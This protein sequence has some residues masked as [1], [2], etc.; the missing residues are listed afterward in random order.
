MHV[1]SSNKYNFIEF[2]CLLKLMVLINGRY[3]YFSLILIEVL[4]STKMKNA[5][6]ALPQ[7]TVIRQFA[8]YYSYRYNINLMKSLFKFFTPIS[9]S[10]ID[11]HFFMNYLLLYRLKHVLIDTLMLPAL[12]FQRKLKQL[13]LTPFV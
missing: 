11:C 3:I 2:K 7:L 5:I 1:D 9:T 6:V 10:K 8:L 4:F 13:P 12:S